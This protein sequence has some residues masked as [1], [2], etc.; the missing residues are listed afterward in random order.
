MQKICLLKRAR[1]QHYS[2]S[3]PVIDKSLQNEQYFQ[4]SYCSLNNKKK[5]ES[6]FDP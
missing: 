2:N 6:P 5:K 4:T 3:K 1:Q